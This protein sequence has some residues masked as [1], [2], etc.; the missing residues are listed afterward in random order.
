MQ[1]VANYG[2]FLQAYALKQ[3]LLE[4]GAESV[5]FLDIIKGRQF[6][7]SERQ[8]RWRNFFI[9]II[10]GKLIQK[11]NTRR[12]LK[13]K[14]SRFIPYY[15]YFENNNPQDTV[16]DLVVIGSDEVFNCC[17][18]SPWGFSSQ[19]FGDVT[20][21][22]NVITYAASFGSTTLDNIEEYG[23]E[24]EISDSLKKLYGISVRDVNSYN[25]IKSLIG[26][27]ALIH[28]DPVLA[29]GYKA[30]LLEDISKIIPKEAYL[31]VYSYAGRIDNKNEIESI[32][33]FAKDNFLK[34]YSLFCKY[35]WC[36]GEIIPEH[37]LQVPTIF[38]CAQ[39]AVTDT[40]HGTIFSIISQ[41][42]FC[43]IIRSNNYQKIVSLLKSVGLENHIAE[44]PES[45]A[46]VLKVA[47]D[48]RI[49]EAI[50]TK[51]RERTKNYLSAYLK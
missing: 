49:V 17:Q 40:F 15:H 35:G 5:D 10:S 34:V 45:I 44:S 6:L 11:I 13:V 38:K 7:P 50:L 8:S 27:E 12:Y 25:I 1:R 42:N 4:Y 20:N 33:K 41:S 37:P 19:L 9:N 14:H 46:S 2:S 24:R 47:I 22:N 26:K 36:D 29:F 32:K 43:T 30:A 3:L 16:Y 51:E 39:Y 28:L 48:Y 31:L 18:R 23:L 21:S